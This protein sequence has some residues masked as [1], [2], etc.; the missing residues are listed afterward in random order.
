M[1]DAI[2]ERA[3]NQIFKVSAQLGCTSGKDA[4]FTLDFEDRKYRQKDLVGLIRDMVPFFAL[5]EEEIQSL[6]KS[7]WNKVSFTRISDAQPSK[8]GD[9]GELLLY[10]ILC[11]FYDSPKFVTKARLRSSTREQIK[12]FD[13]A[14]FSIEG[15]SDVRLWL[16]EAKFHASISGAISSALKS[17]T[18]TF[19]DASRIKSELKLLGGEIEVNKSLSAEHLSTLKAYTK[20]GRSLD[21]IPIQVPVL[22]TYDSKCIAHFNGKPEAD[23]DS[24]S[25]HAQLVKELEESFKSIYSKSWPVKNNITLSFYLVPFESVAGMKAL[26]EQVENVMKF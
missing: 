18:A 26:L 5:T 7:D 24:P 3:R 15:N 14:H 23:L 4:S 25:F 8:K 1:D 17:I 16:G 21:K 13:C 9:Y 6:D 20:G 2:K 22:V 10:V 11:L 12:G 19:T